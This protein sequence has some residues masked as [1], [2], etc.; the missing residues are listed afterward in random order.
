MLQGTKETKKTNSPGVLEAGPQ[1]SQDSWGIGFIGFFCTLQHFALPGLVL[2][3]SLSKSNDL[4][5]DVLF[6]LVNLTIC[7]EIYG[8]A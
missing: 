2:L 3:V 4:A 6:C 7:M 1:D 5:T 8:F